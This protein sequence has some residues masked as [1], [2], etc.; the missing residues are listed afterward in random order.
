MQKKRK[1]V[2]MLSEGSVIV[3]QESGCLV[4][5]T[6]DPDVTP[7]WQG[8]HDIYRYGFAFLVPI[9]INLND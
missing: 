8:Q 4:N 5:L 1:T 9:R 7:E 3:G 6:P 2:H